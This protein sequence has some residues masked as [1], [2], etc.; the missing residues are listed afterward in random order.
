M[1]RRRSTT[2]SLS[3]T[4]T[5][6][7]SRM[8]RVSIWDIISLVFGLKE[9]FETGGITNA[10]KISFKGKMRVFDFPSTRTL[11]SRH[12]VFWGPVFFF[13]FLGWNS[14]A[15]NHENLYM[16]FFWD[17]SF[18]GYL[19]CVFHGSISWAKSGLARPIIMKIFICSFFPGGPQEER[20]GVEMR[21]ARSI[22]IGFTG[23]P[24]T[25]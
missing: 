11:I 12:I 10:V 7:S 2:W 4:R 5:S 17:L 23:K 18:G 25:R 21:D 1:K 13:F 6:I 22:A 3:E 20:S 16:L 19:T 24:S 14:N 9:K 8:P 15:H